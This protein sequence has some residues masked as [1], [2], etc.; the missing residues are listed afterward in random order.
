[1]T[2][3]FAEKA[4]FIGFFSHFCQG[5]FYTL[6]SQ[7]VGY[8]TITADHNPELRDTSDRERLVD[9]PA[10]SDFR[11]LLIKVVEILEEER[12]K[13]R[14]EAR[15]KEPPFKDLFAALSAKDLV[16]EVSRLA[17]EGKNASE[18][19][20]IVED[21]STRLQETVGQIE[22][23]L[24]YYSRLASIGV[25]TAIIVH[26]VR[27][28]TLVIGRLCRVVRKLFVNED[29]SVKKIE[30]DLNLTEQAVRSLE[31]VADRFAP[32]ASRA[33]GT[34][35]R[36]CVLEHTIKECLAMREQEIKAKGVIAECI[37]SSLVTVAVDPGE[38]IAV[39]INLI[40]NSLYWLSHQKDGE[41]RIEFRV[42][43]LANMQRAKVEAHDSG[44]GIQDGDEERIFWPGVTSKPEGLGMGL[45]LLLK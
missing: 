42:S 43:P 37:S 26:E 25:L 27:N 29:S 10:T 40:D 38:L 3:H 22:R 4:V 12:E 39:L 35:R 5:T 13:D 44:P 36:D 2:N 31:R 17:N 41:R 28:Q 9:K 19:V 23:R 16:D 21:F 18:V 8:A 11:K 45:L 32:L 24:I 20:P 7:V 14:Q 15:H 6:L 34:R 30:S 1:M 33:F